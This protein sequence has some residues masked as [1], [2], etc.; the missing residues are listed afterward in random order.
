VPLLPEPALP[1]DPTLL[2]N[3]LREPTTVHIKSHLITI[4]FQSPLSP[5]G[6][7]YLADA[8]QATGEECESASHGITYA[9]MADAVREAS[10]RERR[11]DIDPAELLAAATALI[12]ARTEATDAGYDTGAP[13][14]DLRRAWVCLEQLTEDVC[15]QQAG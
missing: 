9:S 15:A 12:N 10:Q 2:I 1:D 3:I 6:L 13:T 11:M 8:L 4:T 14:A 5:A 7:T